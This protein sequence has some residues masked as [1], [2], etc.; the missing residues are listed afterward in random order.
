MLMLLNVFIKLLISLF[1]MFIL[2]VNIVDKFL[3]GECGE[4][5]LYCNFTPRIIN[6]EC[7]GNIYRKY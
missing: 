1:Y 4:L 5:N 3:V 6:K 2:Y 7:Y